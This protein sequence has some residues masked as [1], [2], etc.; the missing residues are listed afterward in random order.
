MQPGTEACRICRRLDGGH[1]KAMHDMVDNG[2]KAYPAPKKP[3]A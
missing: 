3:T 1:D 2:G